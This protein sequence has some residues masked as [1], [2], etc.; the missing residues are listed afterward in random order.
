MSYLLW[1]FPFDV[2]KR[3]ERR[4]TSNHKPSVGVDSAPEL[5]NRYWH[6]RICGQNNSKA[7]DAGAYAKNTES[8]CDIEAK[9]FFPIEP[10][11]SQDRERQNK[12]ED[13]GGEVEG[14]GDV[15]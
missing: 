12:N 4:E 14:P 11:G 8:K 10:E 1:S 13:I 9:L 2:K 6:V 5:N 7:S 15:P 3:P